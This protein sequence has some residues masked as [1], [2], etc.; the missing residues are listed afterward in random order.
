MWWRWVR[1]VTAGECLAFAVPALAGASLT[2]APQAVLVTA[3]IAAGAVEG[4]VLG[5]A[6]AHVL[7]QMRAG[8]PV[9][10]WVAR[11]A[12]AAAFAWALGLMVAAIVQDASDW[13]LGSLVSA[14][15]ILG[16][17]LLFSIGWAQWTVLRAWFD[18]AWRWIWITALA[19]AVGLGLFTLVTTPLWQPG[20]PTWLVATIGALGGVVMAAAMAAITGGALVRL[21]Q[22]D[23]AAGP[24]YRE[25]ARA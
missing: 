5:W 3:L 1:W 8:F 15:A 7:R 6:Q 12:G 20:Q 2:D 18:R 9:R 17:G 4:A 19:W 10:V 14:T 21:P 13:P 25:G 22:A 16:I 11:T 24:R 23:R